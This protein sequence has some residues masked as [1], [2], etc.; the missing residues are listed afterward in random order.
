MVF[1]YEMDDKND[2]SG[3]SKTLGS[4]LKHKYCATLITSNQQA[5]SLKLCI[6][7]EFF[8]KLRFK[9][10]LHATYQLKTTTLLA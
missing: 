4:N 9:L 5:L 7:V 10:S 3:A 8:K 1:K 6:L 2:G